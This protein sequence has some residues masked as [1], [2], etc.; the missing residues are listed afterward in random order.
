MTSRSTPPSSGALGGDPRFTDLT[1]DECERLLARNHVGRI[2]FSHSNRVDIEPI[3]YVYEKGWLFGRTSPG[4]KLM[5][6]GH[7]PWVAFE[8][9]EVRGPLD[10]E[11]VVVHGSFRL[12]EPGGS[13]YDA[14]LFARAIAMLRAVDP[15]MGTPQDAVPFRTAVYGV[16]VD[17]MTGRRAR[18]DVREGS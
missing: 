9:D 8:I 16:H 12:L 3:G 15:A 1:P 10:W 4:T 13:E 11:S 6:L 14:D 5:A 17:E 18:S 7:R 2:A